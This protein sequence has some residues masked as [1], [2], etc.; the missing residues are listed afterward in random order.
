AVRGG[1]GGRGD[2][3]VLP[4]PQRLQGRQRRTRPR[5]RRRAPEAR[6]RAPAHRGARDRPGGAHRRRRVR[7]PRRRPRRRGQRGVLRAR[8]RG[9]G[10][11]VLGVG[12]PARG[13]LEPRRGAARRR[14]VG[15]PRPRRR[16]DVPRQAARRGS[17]GRGRLRRRRRV[18]RRRPG[19]SGCKLPAMS[20]RAVL[21]LLTLSAMFGAS[22]LFMRVA[23]PVLGPV[24][25]V[26]VRVAL[27]GLTLLAYGLLS[28]RLRRPGPGWWRYVVTGLLQ[29]ALPFALFATASLTLTASF[30]STLSATPPIATALVAALWLGDRLTRRGVL[31]LRLGLVGV[32]VLVGFGPLPLT[33]PVLLATGYSLRAAT[34]YAFAA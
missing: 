11:A 15:R 20:P 25:L 4:G 31:G 7:D 10:R 26:E 23:A 1:R 29:S 17:R 16:R 21:A 24:L 28:G 18:T 8:P 19:P 22:F 27:A 33:R 5:G 32:A 12:P 13:L 9:R 2:G 6:S 3:A 14:P 34:S 30:T